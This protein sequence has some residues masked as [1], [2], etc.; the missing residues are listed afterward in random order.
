MNEDRFLEFDINRV[1]AIINSMT[2]ATLMQFL[3]FIM[4]NINID[5]GVPIDKELRDRKKW[6]SIKVER[7]KSAIE[8]ILT[9]PNYRAKIHMLL[10]GDE[11]ISILYFRLVWDEPRAWFDEAS[12]KKL[13]IEKIKSNKTWGDETKKLE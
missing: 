5:I 8:H 13:G 1:R 10:G 6:N 2:K 9:L 11:L 3:E 7:F 12:L 4:E